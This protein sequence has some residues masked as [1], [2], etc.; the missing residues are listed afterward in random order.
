MRGLIVVGCSGARPSCPVRRLRGCGVAINRNHYWNLASG[1]AKAFP[2]MPDLSKIAPPVLK[3]ALPYLKHAEQLDSSPGQQSPMMAYFCRAYAMDLGIKVWTRALRPPWRS[4]V[5]PSP[6]VPPLYRAR[7]P[8]CALFDVRASD[9][10]QCM[11][12]DLAPP[13]NAPSPSV[14]RC[15]IGTHCRSTRI[16]PMRRGRR[17]SSSRS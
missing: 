16:I 2:A 15:R 6:H 14:A 13:R 11:F 3:P 1:E 10:V 8:L 5:P 12:A 17:I 9:D 7:V 4:P